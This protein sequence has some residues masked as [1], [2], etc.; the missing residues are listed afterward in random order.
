LVLERAL[1]QLSEQLDQRS[2]A[3]AA[4]IPLLGLADFLARRG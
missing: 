3:E 1:Y 2:N 4:A